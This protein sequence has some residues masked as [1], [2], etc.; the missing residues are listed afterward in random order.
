MPIDQRPLKS[1]RCHRQGMSPIPERLNGFVQVLLGVAPETTFA[2]SNVSPI[3]AIRFQ[4][5]P[6]IPSNSTRPSVISASSLPSRFSIA[7]RRVVLHRLVLH[8]LV[9]VD[10]QVVVVARDLGLGHEETL[11]SACA[12]R[13]RPFDPASERGCPLGRSSLAAAC[14]CHPASSHPLCIS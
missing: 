9:A 5:H 12:L 4:L 6:N 7:C 1:F 11:V 14:A 8:L 10:G 2:K 3:V 13:T